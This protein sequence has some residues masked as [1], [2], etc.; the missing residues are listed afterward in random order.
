MV[1]L[2]HPYMTTGKTTA[3]TRQT[4]V[5]KVISLLLNI[6]SRFVRAFLP[7]RKHVLMSWLQSPSAVTLEPKKINFA[8]VS[9]VSPSVCHEMTGPDAVILVRMLSFKSAFS[10]S[11]STSLTRLSSFCAEPSPTQPWPLSQAPAPPQL[12]ERSSWPLPLCLGGNPPG[13]EAPR[14]SPTS[15]FYDL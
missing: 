11:S 3:L 2:S 8:T 14:A 7:R 4:F 5:S 12:C 1:Q 9:T 15:S 13:S 6:L 10:A